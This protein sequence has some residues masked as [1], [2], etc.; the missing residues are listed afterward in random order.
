MKMKKAQGSILAYSLII[1]AV[2]FSIVGTMSTVT[3]L[4]KKSAGASQ[5]SSQAFQI[6]DSGVQSAVK[7]INAVL[8]NSNNKLSDAFPSGECAVLDGVATVKGSLSTDMLYE[9]TFFKV[10]TTTLIDDC[11]RQVT[12]VGDI[13]AIGTFKKTI[14][15]VQVSV[16]HCS[17]DLI[18]DKKDNSIDYKEVLGEDGN[19]W[20]DRNLG[21]E[22]VATSATDPLAYGWLFQW[23]R[24]NDGHQDRTS[25]TSNIPSSSI[26]PPGHKF[27]FYPH[28]PWNW[29]N[30]VTPNANDLWQDDGIN[31]P[32]PD[33][34]RLPTGGAGGE[35]ENF[36]SSAGLKNCT[37]GCLDKLYQTS[38]KITVAGTR[39]GTNATV[40]LAGE[41]GFYWSSTYNTSNNNSYLLRFS[42]MTIPTTANAI[43]TTGSSV[44]CIKD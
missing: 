33:G 6:A 32:C 39:G 13:K 42:N 20:L 9:I 40:A 34:Y 27:I 7:K 12:E 16:R 35:W 36:I 3:I 19:C 23:G 38:L 29:Y 14:R 43:K 8:K 44:R 17:T 31:N 25:N 1:L 28:A 5:S 10:G 4:E 22:Q 21:A 2:M 41:Q 37:A 26:D 30:G 11:G 24:G 15:A 18:P